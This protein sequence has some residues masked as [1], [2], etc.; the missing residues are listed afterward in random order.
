[1]NIQADRDPEIVGYDF[2]SLVAPV[3]GLLSNLFGGG[4]KTPPPPPPVPWFPI[5]IGSGTV[6]IVVSLIATRKK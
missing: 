1:M 3:T 2:S 6:L 5:I 4:Q